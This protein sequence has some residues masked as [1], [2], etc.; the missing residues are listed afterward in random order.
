MIQKTYNNSRHDEFI[1]PC[2]QGNAE[3]VDDHQ[4]NTELADIQCDTGLI[5][6]YHPG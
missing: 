6:S 1:Q 3:T 2:F 4:N 5:N